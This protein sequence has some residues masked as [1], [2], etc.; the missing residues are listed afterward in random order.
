MLATLGATGVLTGVKSEL[1]VMLPPSARHAA[2]PS[3]TSGGKFSTR[4][5]DAADAEDEPAR[6]AEAPSSLPMFIVPGVPVLDPASLAD[7]TS[8]TGFDATGPSLVDARR[9]RGVT[10]QPVRRRVAA[11][12][13]ALIKRRSSDHVIAMT[14]LPDLPADAVSRS[15]WDRPK[16]IYTKVA[17][18]G[19]DMVDRLTTW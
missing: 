2:G 16:A 10:S 7:P 5:I 11:S 1:R 4:A 18:W 17:S 3:L 14:T 13:L 19:D 15:I 8:A 12:S 6:P 9:G